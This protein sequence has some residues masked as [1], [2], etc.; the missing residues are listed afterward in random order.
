M[1]V[2]E[3]KADP[4]K[5]SYQGSWYSGYVCVGGGY[6][7]DNSR[8]RYKGYT[9]ARKA[10]NARYDEKMDRLT[11]RMPKGDKEKLQD[12]CKRNNTSLNAFVLDAIAQKMDGC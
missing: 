3:G 1:Y 8:G 7:A 10:A 5:K 4:D 2:L 6:M 11:V 12:H 9:P